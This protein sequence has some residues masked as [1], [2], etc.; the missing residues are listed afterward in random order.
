[1]PFVSKKQW[2]WAFATGQP[3]AREAAHKTPG[4]KKVR[5]KRLPASKHSGLTG[6]RKKR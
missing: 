5:F 3:W 2:R 1:M 6:R 4:G